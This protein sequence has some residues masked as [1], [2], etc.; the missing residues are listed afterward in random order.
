MAFRR[1][2]HAEGFELL[3]TLGA[4]GGVERWGNVHFA[5]L[6]ADLGDEHP[7]DGDHLALVGF[8]K[9]SLE[10]PIHSNILQLQA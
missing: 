1:Q 6:P 5:N 8:G 10:S 2:S 3:G 4:G 7:D 9:P